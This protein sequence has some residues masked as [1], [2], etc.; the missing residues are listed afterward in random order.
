[1]EKRRWKRNEGAGGGE[2][3]DGKA[4][5]KRSLAETKVGTRRDPEARHKRAA[6]FRPRAKC[7]WKFFVE[8]RRGD[9]LPQPD[10]Y[11]VRRRL[12]RS[13]RRRRRRRWERRRGEAERAEGLKQKG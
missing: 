12:P 10:D 2:K 13:K 7:Y 6:A 1:M 5:V 3:R 4:R 9:Q 11:K 8:K